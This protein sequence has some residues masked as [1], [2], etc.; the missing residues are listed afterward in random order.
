M[1]A[2]IYARYSTDNQNENSIDT[3]VRLCKKF[4]DERGMN[5]VAIFADEAQSGM[6]LA[7]DGFQKLIT[8]I[9]NHLFHAVI[10]YDQSRLSRDLVDWFLLRKMISSHGVELFSVLR[11][12]F[13]DL[14]D[15]TV[16]LTESVEAVFNQLH[17]LTTRKK[18]IEGMRNI[19]MKCQFTGGRACL[20]YDV[21]NQQ[22]QINEDE[23]KIIRLIFDMYATGNSYSDILAKL[24]KIGAKTKAGQP[25][26]TNSL[27]SILRNEKYIGTYIYG[28]VKKRPDGKRNSHAIAEDAIRIENAIPPIIS[29]DIW[30]IVQKRLS[31]NKRNPSYK[32]KVDYLLTGSIYCGECGSAMVAETSNRRYYYYSCCGKKRLKNCNKT[33]VNKENVENVVIDEIK[34][35]LEHE[36]IDIIAEKI[37]NSM[38]GIGDSIPKLKRSI[39]NEMERI[40]KQIQ[41]INAAIADG[42]W[43][44]STAATLSNLEIRLEELNQELIN[45][46]CTAESTD[47]TLDDVKRDLYALLDAN[48]ANDR[49]L[50]ISLYVEKVVCFNDGTVDITI[51][52][53]RL[54]TD[55]KPVQTTWN[56]KGINKNCT[57][58]NGAADRT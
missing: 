5:V 46:D 9:Q 55:P 18:T 39:R 6:K 15:P 29:R 1:D 26:G 25:F 50:L 4:A 31:N 8:G 56:G 48:N 54:N 16:F 58:M 10:I 7:R 17:V 14:T 36:S 22:Y 40:N 12:E 24:N 35:F 33:S 49:R 32:A 13:G 27:S 37:Y 43:N 23:A 44:K 51:N 30:D 57:D 2:A 20:G 45:L 34:S 38:E 41:N 21:I 3:Q 11:G 47:K 52:P 19:A 53:L 28:K 42:I